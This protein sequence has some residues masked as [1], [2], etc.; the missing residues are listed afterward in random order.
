VGALRNYYGV[1]PLI[2]VKWAL[3]TIQ[4]HMDIIAPLRD[5]DDTM[6][7]YGDRFEGLAI[8]FQKRCVT[9]IML[10]QQPVPFAY[11]HILK[12]QTLIVLLLIGYSVSSVFDEWFF[13]SVAFGVI[14]F[15]L[16]GLQEIAVAMADP[17]GDDDMDFET[18]QLLETTYI[19]VLSYLREDFQVRS[20]SHVRHVPPNGLV[21]P[22]LLEG[23]SASQLF[24]EALFDSAKEEEAKEEPPP[25]F[26]KSQ[27][28]RWNRNRSRRPRPPASD[29]LSYLAA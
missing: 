14:C 29:D 22:L 27:A 6:A 9:I 15:V 4:D 16:L 8:D 10:I 20:V 11:F 23:Q 19:N 1:K 26:S 2:V 17:F 7:T 28:T 21:N 18:R 5:R 24:C 12:V 3:A 13:A 25:A